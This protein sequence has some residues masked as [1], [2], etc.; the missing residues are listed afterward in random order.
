MPVEEF[1]MN[2]P[3]RLKRILARTKVPLKD[4]ASLRDK[5]D[6]LQETSVAWSFPH[7]FKRRAHEG[8]QDAA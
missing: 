8:E 3:E 7:R 4:A 5:M 1:L 2:D 6:S